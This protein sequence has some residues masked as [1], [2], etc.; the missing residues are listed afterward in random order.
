MV[1]QLKIFTWKQFHNP[2]LEFKEAGYYS[3]MKKLVSKNRVSGRL[4][5]V[6][7]YVIPEETID[8]SGR[9]TSWSRS[10][11]IAKEFAD[12]DILQLDCDQIP[13]LELEGTEEEVIL[14]EMTLRILEKNRSG[15]LVVVK[16]T[17]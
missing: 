1:V 15:D 11:K 10:L 14:D 2:V 17:L 3:E 9:S 8:Y 16:V 12:P 4:Y 13:G 5:R 6:T 7:D